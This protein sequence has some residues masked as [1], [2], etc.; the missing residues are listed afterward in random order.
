MRQLADALLKSP[1][2]RD[3][4]LSYNRISAVGARALAE[5]RDCTMP[6]CNG[7]KP[8]DIQHTVKIERSALT[9]KKLVHPRLLSCGEVCC[10]V[11]YELRPDVSVFEEW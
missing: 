10:S 4:D 7:W 11:C 3:V 5:V 6:P 2:V 9:Q 8:I 1:S